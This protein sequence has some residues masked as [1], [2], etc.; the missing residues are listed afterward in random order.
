MGQEKFEVKMVTHRPDLIYFNWRDLGGTYKVYR[1]G[2][3]LYEGTVPEFGDGSFQHAQMYSYSI[4]RIVDE[5]VVDVI[6]LQTTA[7]AE[8]RNVKN[9][10]Q[11]LVMTTIVAKTQIALSWEGIEDV[12][13]YA[14]FRDGVHVKTIRETQYIDRDFSLEESY[15]YKIHSKRPLRK[16]KDRLGGSK[17]VLAVIFGKLR[18]RNAFGE[19]AIEQFSVTKAI[20]K[21]SK[22]LTPVLDREKKR[23][24]DRWRFRYTTFLKEAFIQNPNILSKYRYFQGD[25]R[26]FEV[27]G[28]TYR[29][30]VDLNLA[31]D[32]PGMPLT[33]T[34]TVGKTTAYDRLKRIRKVGVA[35]GEEVRLKRSD[36]KK[37]EAGFQLIHS[38]GNPLVSAPAIDYE[39]RAVMRKDG[40][41][42]L[43]GY[44]DQAPNHEIYLQR[45]EDGGWFPLHLAES[46]GLA[47]LSP[48][49]AWQYWRFSN[50]G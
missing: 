6:A 41:Y 12:E 15:T 1:N 49:V 7:F 39:V 48:I 10:L 43:T 4:E 9:P 13:E 28:R 35:S 25:G 19:P 29:T 47:W 22:L 18:R 24:I 11:S 33:F 3:L 36:H 42:D 20:A 27:D 2:Q 46:K 31:Y 8:Q 34:R 50:F 26:E 30:R 32:E 38:V 40:T 23:S 45:G 16:S 37:G 21:P 17:S 44:H 14:I 5:K